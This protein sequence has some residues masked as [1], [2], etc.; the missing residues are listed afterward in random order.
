LA[1]KIAKYNQENDGVFLLLVKNRK[2][3]A[4]KQFPEKF[5]LQN[6][7]YIVRRISV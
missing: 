7:A 6:K 3:V 4:L 1:E 2:V 5:N